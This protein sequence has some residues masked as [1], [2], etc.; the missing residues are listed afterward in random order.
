LRPTPSRSQ[1]R[2]QTAAQSVVVPTGASVRRQS[3]VNG[4]SEYAESS[5]PPSSR[6]L[7]TSRSSPTVFTS[8]PSLL[9][10]PTGR[11]GPPRSPRDSTVPVAKSIVST[12]P[13]VPTATIRVGSRDHRSSG[14]K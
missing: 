14:P 11:S 10:S 4:V 3:R 8:A 5:V 12:V 9:A 2:H 1:A 13:A 7:T 6:R